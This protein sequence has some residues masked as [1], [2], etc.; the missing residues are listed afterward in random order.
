MLIISLFSYI[1]NSN[2][3]NDISVPAKAS[4]TLDLNSADNSSTGKK[5]TDKEIYYS[6]KQ[7]E[8][9]VLRQN[10]KNLEKNKEW[11]DICEEVKRLQNFSNRAHIF[12][13]ENNLVTSDESSSHDAHR[14]EK[15]SICSRF[16]SNE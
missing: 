10:K 1:Y 4:M 11:L 6:S 12:Y 7:Y 14:G 9:Y 13:C 3:I 16:N 2:V 8:N 5:Y 15:R